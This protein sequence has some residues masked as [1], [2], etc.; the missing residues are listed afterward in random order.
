MPESRGVSVYK[1][2]VY[3][4]EENVSEVSDEELAQ[5]AEELTI[6]QAID[7]LR[8]SDKYKRIFLHQRKKGLLP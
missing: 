2:G 5:E 7:S 6:K 4:G 3:V 1:D 8:D